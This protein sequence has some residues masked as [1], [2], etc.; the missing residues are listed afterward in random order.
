MANQDCDQ[1][2]AKE[3]R[4]KIV[5]VDPQGSTGI[6]VPGLLRYR[7]RAK[8]WKADPKAGRFAEW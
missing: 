5:A 6:T 7:L 4:W 1:G 8:R 2:T 3:T